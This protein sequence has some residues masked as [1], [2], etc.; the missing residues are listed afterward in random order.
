MSTRR[1]RLIDSKWLVE[2]SPDDVEAEDVGLDLARALAARHLEL[3]DLG[4]RETSAVTSALSPADWIALERFLA[5]EQ[6]SPPASLVVPNAS[7]G[8]SRPDAAA[9]SDQRHGGSPRDRAAADPLAW[10]AVGPRWVAAAGV[11]VLLGWLA[12]RFG[13]QRDAP[14]PGTSAD[15]LAWSPLVEAA[16]P[17]AR[18]EAW[19]G[20]ASSRSSKSVVEPSADEQ[21]RTSGLFD[22]RVVAVRRQDAAFQ[23]GVVVGPRTVLTLMSGLGVDTTVLCRD[24][25]RW[26]ARACAIET[27]LPGLGLATLV[28]DGKQFE[29]WFDLAA[30]PEVVPAA[31][32]KPD[33]AAAELPN[34]STVGVYGF[35]GS[36]GGAVCSSNHEVAVGDLIFTDCEMRP[37]LGGGALLEGGEGGALI[38]VVVGSRSNGHFVVAVSVDALR[39]RLFGHESLR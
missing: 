19:L 8:K 4:E 6:P 22:L 17:A 5:G 14:S 39:H 32:P 1:G 31:P 28:V 3:C 36:Q 27:L 7:A 18:L 38:G 2:E 24:G 12:V 25:G 34:D 30:R 16:I 37:G 26:T 29:A 35:G 13:V 11:L 9:R 10:L 33:D 21:R 15:R 20:G 23:S